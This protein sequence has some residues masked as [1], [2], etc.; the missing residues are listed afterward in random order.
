MAGP[1]RKALEILG[2][3]SEPELNP[4]PHSY[5]AYKP[6]GVPWLGNVPAHWDVRPNRAV[7]KEI[8][9]RD[10]PGEQLLSV[11]IAHGVILQ[12]A[13]FRDSSQ[14]DSSRLD[15]SA[16][17]LV[18]PGDLAYNKMRAWQGALGVSKY[19][20]I[21]SPAYIVQRPCIASNPLYFHYLLRTPAFAAEAERWSYGIA[22]DM[23]SLRSEHFRMIQCCVPPLSEQNAIVRFLDRMDRRIR[24]YVTAMQKLISLLDEEKLSI[25]NQAVTRGLDQTVR[26]RP[27][28]TEWLGDVP[29]H[30]EVVQLGR[31]GRF[32]KGSGG[33]KEDKGD[34]GF[35]CI[36][37]GDIYTNFKYH[38]EHARS[39]I[40]REQSSKYT[41]LQ[42]GDI[43]FAG[44]GE[45]LVSWI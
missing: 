27:S 5:P 32:S 4:I 25:V 45:T 26:L 35:P 23:W 11:T 6:S 29:E 7:F 9:E 21:V 17:K 1:I 39:Y 28:G 24:R 31:I 41:P 16:Y 20:G 42:Y 30:W 15:K 13:L 36:W 8:I 34:S 14:K 44:S 38:I 19:Q 2:I 3:E 33:S 18:R 12:T 37:Y 43:L 40:R 22:S 10:H